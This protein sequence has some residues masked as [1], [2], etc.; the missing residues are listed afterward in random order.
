MFVATGGV[1]LGA[2]ILKGMQLVNDPLA[3]NELLPNETV[4]IAAVFV[5]AVLGAWLMA[6]VLPQP[7]RALGALCFCVF[8]VVSIRQA[9]IG[10]SSCGC[11]GQV[12]VTPW[13]TA[14]F[15]LAA[16]VMLC[17]LRPPPVARWS[18][19]FACGIGGVL[20]VLTAVFTWRLM[21]P[22]ADLA[23]LAASPKIIDL[24][25][26]GRGQKVEVEI[27]LSNRSRSEIQYASV[28]TSCPC[29]SISPAKGAVAPG[30]SI[31]VAVLFDLAK[32]PD[33][34]GGLSMT[35]KGY[36]PERNLVFQLTVT[37]EVRK[38]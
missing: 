27:S 13:L 4:A 19:S 2:A 6:G 10:R 25:A 18:R 9:V 8:C 26:I 35:A 34:V 22:D 30:S 5:E 37:A 20:V 11:F 29:L 23:V 14:A 33:F 21:S 15:D 38:Q 31:Q 3:E 17:A 16:V 28:E 12:H 24:G 32:E 7:A 1:L 36:S